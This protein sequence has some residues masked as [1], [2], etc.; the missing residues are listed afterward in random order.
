M[1]S[2]PPPVPLEFDCYE[3]TIPRDLF[4]DCRYSIV[5]LCRL[6]MALSRS[7]RSYKLGASR[8]GIRTSARENRADGTYHLTGSNRARRGQYGSEPC[9]ECYRSIK[10]SVRGHNLV[11]VRRR[12]H[13]V[14][15]KYE[16]QKLESLGR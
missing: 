6:P 9:R 10:V 15:H 1:K 5:R 2:P 8:L 3:A 11:R 4:L 16:R 14:L 13:D 12:T 7:T